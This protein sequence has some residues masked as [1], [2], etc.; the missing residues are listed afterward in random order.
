MAAADA[1]V[2]VAVD[3]LARDEAAVD[4]ARDD[5]VVDVLSDVV[6]AFAAA[7]ARVILLGG[8]AGSIVSEMEGQ[9]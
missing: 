7:R 6:V 2:A 4:F 3:V 5:A 1:V 9:K 8:D